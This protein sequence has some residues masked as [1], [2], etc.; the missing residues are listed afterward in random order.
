MGGGAGEDCA[1]GVGEAV[2]V[3][4]VWNGV[5]KFVA[6]ASGVRAGVGTVRA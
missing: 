2:S 6:C 3:G 4:C 5:F 1:V